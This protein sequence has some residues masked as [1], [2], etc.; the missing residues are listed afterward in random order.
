MLTHAAPAVLFSAALPGQG[1]TCHIT[2]R[3]SS[4][5]RRLFAEHGFDR[6][7]PIRRRV[8]FDQRVEW[9]YQQ[10]VY[11][12]VSK[13][14][15]AASPVLQDEDRLARQCPLELARCS[16]L[17]RDESFRACLRQLVRSAWRAVK[18]RLTLARKEL[19][20]E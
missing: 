19:P 7:D 10:N 17:E 5:W 6:L 9:W 20:C 3:W 2:E 1:G 14:L 15:L 16:I 11:L 13:G 8:W 4:W 12:Y 18:T